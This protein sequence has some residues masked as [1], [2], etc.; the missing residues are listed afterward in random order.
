MGPKET[1]TILPKTKQDL[2]MTKEDSLKKTAMKLLRE[3]V[4]QLGK[5]GAQAY[6]AVALNFLHDLTSGNVNKE[7][8]P[9]RIQHA[10]I[11][12]IFLELLSYAEKDSKN[13][14]SKGN[15]A[16]DQ[17]DFKEAIDQYANFV[18]T[19]VN[20]GGFFGAGIASGKGLGIYESDAHAPWAFISGFLSGA[21]AEAMKASVNTYRMGEDVVKACGRKKGKLD[22]RF[23]E[24]FATHG[25]NLLGNVSKGGLM[26]T[27]AIAL[28]RALV[29]GD[30]PN[31]SKLLAVTVPWMLGDAL[32][33]TGA[34][35]SALLARGHFKAPRPMQ[36]KDMAEESDDYTSAAPAPGGSGSD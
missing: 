27:I 13:P 11:P 28:D 16:F 21:I 22:K 2:S 17:Y 26:T 25:L 7:D 4:T 12:L 1:D 8:I 32:L 33:N 10:F 29:L 15:A 36:T 19:G 34:K 5:A 20:I 6:I 30:N 35:D 9:E 31:G 24:D 18:S 14:L 3:M 23:V